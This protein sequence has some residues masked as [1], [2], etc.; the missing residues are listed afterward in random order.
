MRKSIIPV[1]TILA[2]MSFFTW[3]YCGKTPSSLPLPLTGS[4]RITAIATD[5]S[6]IDSIEVNLDDEDYGTL[7]NPCVLTDIV[8][9]FHGLRIQ[10]GAIAGTTKIVEVLRDQ[11]THTDFLLT[12]EGPHQGQIAPPFT[13]QD[14]NGN[15]ISLENLKG[16]VVLL[17]FFEHT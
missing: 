2:S 17:L 12:P 13:S 16:K 1:L 5:Q 4:I 8:I 14:I 10:H 7:D 3:Q 15:T 9:G 6:P 11:T